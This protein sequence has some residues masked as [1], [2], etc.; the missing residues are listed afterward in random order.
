[1]WRGDEVLLAQR[2]KALGY[3]YWS[4]PGGKVEPGETAIEAAVRELYE[5]TCVIGE[6]KHHVGDFELDGSDVQYLISCFTGAYISGDALAMTDATAV[7]WV[8]WQE[9]SKYKLAFNSAEAVV[10]ARKLTSV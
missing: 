8:H 7:A 10:L 6:L 9:I 3:G 5:E 4:L 1:M 2:G